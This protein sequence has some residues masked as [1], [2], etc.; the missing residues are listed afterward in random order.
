MIIISV[1]QIILFLL[2]VVS[3]SGWT[4][5][6]LNKKSSKKD[7]DKANEDFLKK[8]NSMESKLEMSNKDWESKLELIQTS[9]DSNVFLMES[10]HE[11]ELKEISD[12]ADSKI[13]DIEKELLASVELYEKYITN[14]DMII[15]VSHQKIR[16]VDSKG[17]YKT[18]DE[19]QFFFEALKE[20]QSNLDKFQ[21]EKQD[22]ENQ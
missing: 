13:K 16:E 15:Q 3:T 9:H 19:V 20:I 4:F 10:Q 14:L 22:S 11:S 21:V 2:V 18:D 7:L 6:F 5:Y 8:L 1:N 12:L 17:I